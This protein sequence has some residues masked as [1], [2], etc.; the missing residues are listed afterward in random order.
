MPLFARVSRES[1]R[2]IEIPLVHP[3]TSIEVL[4]SQSVSPVCPPAPPFRRFHISRVS[5]DPLLNPLL[6][7]VPI[8]VV[9]QEPYLGD[10]G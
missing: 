9:S 4:P 5:P 3:D 10:R 2:G 6:T 1:A 8:L 7:S